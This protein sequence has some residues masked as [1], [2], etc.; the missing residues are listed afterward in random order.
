MIFTDSDYSRP[1]S[2]RLRLRRPGSGSSI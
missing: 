2:F 1:N